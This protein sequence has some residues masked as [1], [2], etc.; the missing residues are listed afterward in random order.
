METDLQTNKINV[1]I[2]ED[3]YL[4]LLLSNVR[5]HVRRAKG[6]ISPLHFIAPLISHDCK[7]N[8][9]LPLNLFQSRSSFVEF[10]HY[11]NI[12]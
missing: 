9:N 10:P 3:I 11:I 7:R 6:P 5:N 12:A 8:Q 2:V 4:H 1:T